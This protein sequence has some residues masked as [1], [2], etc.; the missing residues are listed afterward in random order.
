MTPVQIAI[1]A[2]I[3]L[4]PAAIVADMLGLIPQRRWT[5]KSYVDIEGREWVS[6]TQPPKATGYEG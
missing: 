5:G 6:F 1:L 3:V 4:L 2:P